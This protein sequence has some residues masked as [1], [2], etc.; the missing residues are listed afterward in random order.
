MKGIDLRQSKEYQ[1]YMKRLGWQ[2]EKGMFIKKLWWLPWSMIKIQRQNNL[3][4]AEVTKISKKHRALLVKI[5][6]AID[7]KTNYEKWGFKLDKSP[8]LPTKTIWIDLKKSQSR[9]LK[10]MHHKTRYNIKKHKR[11]DVKILRGDK[12][13]K[14]TLESFFEIYK[15]NCKEQKYWGLGFKQ[16][17]HLV[18]AFSDKAYLLWVKNLGGLIVT[19]YKGVVYYAHNGA[20]KQGKKEFLPTILAWEA[21][22]L[23]RKLGCKKFDFEGVVDERFKVTR[24]WLGFSRFKKSFGG[25][26][27]EYMGSFSKKGVN[28]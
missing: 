3:K 13:D 10:E 1:N 18:K 11:R 4:Q 22:K 19:T 9:L 23:G 14:K 21:I 5:E 27:I 2:V 12:I 20:S 24:K 25:D 16:I 28:L 15:Q 17:E 6:P 7:D 26:T 8:L